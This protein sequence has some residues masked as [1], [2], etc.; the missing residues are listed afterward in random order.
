MLIR[1]GEHF[2]IREGNLAITFQQN[3][4]L[5][6]WLSP[7]LTQYDE[8]P[9]FE[10][11][12]VYEWFSIKRS[13]LYQRHSWIWSKHASFEIRAELANCDMVNCKILQNDFDK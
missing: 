1:Q 5:N 12:I 6:L 11:V 7:Y 2:E 9:L 4:L 13:L 3:V 10:N 8:K